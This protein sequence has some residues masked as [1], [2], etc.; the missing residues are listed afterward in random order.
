MV[1]RSVAM[2]AF[3][4]CVICAE[5][6]AEQAPEFGR[7]FTAGTLRIDIVHAGTSQNEEVS[8]RRLS[9]EP[10]WSG[11]PRG[12]VSMWDRG[13]Y[14][15]DVYHRKSGRLVYRHGF[16]TLFGEWQ[17]TPGA[18]LGRRAFEETLE[19]PM[20][21]DSVEV[22]LYSRS[23]TGNMERIFSVDI[24]PNSH[25]IGP[26]APPPAAVVKE[27]EIHGEPAAKVD[28]LVLGDGYA[29]GEQAKFDGDCERFLENFFGA[30]PFRAMRDR[31]NVRTVFVPANDSGVDEPRKGAFADTPFDMTFSM[32]D[33]PRYCMTE[34]V[35]AVHD[36][37]SLAP[38]DAILLMANSSRYGGGAVYNYYTVFVSDNEYD[39]YLTVHEFGHGFAGLADEYYTSAVAYNDFYPAGVEP[40]EPNITALLDSSRVKWARFVESGTPLPTPIGDRRFE[41][42]VGAF[43]GAGYAARG[44]YRPAQDCKMFSKGNKRLCPVCV[45]A[46]TE[47]IEFYAP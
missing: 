10:V 43:E 13:R 1:A 11:S 9:R 17:S 45:A 42:R 18:I 30:Q 41:G 47:M 39:D 32:F 21:R 38:H 26:T 46:V 44:L 20:P 36:A 31:F 23:R 27:I 19:L 7:Y 34:A 37:A 15:M 33:L 25:L 35:W 16:S 28:V 29:A 3:L 24:E 4:V 8:V 14:R 40:T 12:L 5:V 22:V 6:R 2:F